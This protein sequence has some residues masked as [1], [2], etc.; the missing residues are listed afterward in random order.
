MTTS[1]SASLFANLLSSQS[2]SP[3]SRSV[4]ERRQKK[5][6]SVVSKTESQRCGLYCMYLHESLNL[7]FCS[8]NSKMFRSCNRSPMRNCPNVADIVVGLE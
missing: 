4:G 6:N 1:S 7:L 3:S 5:V 2:G 8:V